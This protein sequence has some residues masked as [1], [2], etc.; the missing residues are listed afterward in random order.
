[1]FN[2]AAIA[3]MARIC[4]ANRNLRIVFVQDEFNVLETVQLF[5]AHLTKEGYHGNRDVFFSFGRELEDELVPHT[6]F[7]HIEC[8]IAGF[9]YMNNPLDNVA[10]YIGHRR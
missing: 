5:G 10:G 4:C 1:M 3:D 2:G 6:G 8:Q 7:L 9:W